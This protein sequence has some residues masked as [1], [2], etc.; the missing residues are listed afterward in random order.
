MY[1]FQRFQ[2]ARIG[3]VKISLNTHLRFLRVGL[4]KTITAILLLLSVVKKYN[5]ICIS[6]E[7]LTENPELL[8]NLMPLIGEASES[9]Q[10]KFNQVVDRS[11]IRG[12]INVSKNAAELSRKSTDKRELELTEVIS[13]IRSANGFNKI[14]EFAGWVDDFTA[15]GIARADNQILE[16]LSNIV[17]KW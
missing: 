16:R 2:H 8:N 14:Y 15:E 17:K 10:F 6:Y 1:I 12:D 9:S 13:V 11:K 5:G 7:K 4:E 3:G